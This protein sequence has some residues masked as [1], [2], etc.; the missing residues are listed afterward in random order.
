MSKYQRQ[1]DH[2]KKLKHF[3][4]R[5]KHDDYGRFRVACENLGTLPS[6]EV[7]R[8]VFEVIKRD[9]NIKYKKD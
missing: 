4:I 8:H 6:T 7:R 3:G 1:I 2:Q 5:L 9:E